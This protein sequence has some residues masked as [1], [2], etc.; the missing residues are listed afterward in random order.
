VTMSAA[1]SVTATFNVVVAGPQI[2]AIVDGVTY[3]STI[4]PTTTI[5][6]FGSGFSVGGNM[7]QLQRPGYGDV[8]LYNGDGHYFW[9]YNGTQINA[10]LDSRVASGTWSVI[11]RNSSGAVSNSYSLTVQGNITPGSSAFYCYSSSYSSYGYQNWL[12]NAAYNPT[13]CYTINWQWTTCPSSGGGGGSASVCGNGTCEAGENGSNCGQDC[14]DQ[15][16]PCGQTKQNQGGYYCR[17]MY[18]Y[19]NGSSSWHGF[20]WVTANETT[21]MCNDSWEAWESSYY[22]TQYQCGGYSGKCH[23]IPGGYY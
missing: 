3:G 14:C 9:D 19:D 5:T 10:S 21:Q 8:W 16:T 1:Q 11:V 18:Y 12:C 23:S 20:T 2:S 17:N 15:S 13:Y 22:Q 4:T 7:V 6:I